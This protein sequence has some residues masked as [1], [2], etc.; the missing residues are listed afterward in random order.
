MLQ[1]QTPLGAPS[2]G[3]GGLISQ[4][5]FLLFSFTLT[6]HYFWYFSFFLSF[7]NFKVSSA[8]LLN[9]NTEVIWGEGGGGGCVS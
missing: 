5:N 1:N 3:D 6:H 7:L 8:I 4:L 2:R 9:I